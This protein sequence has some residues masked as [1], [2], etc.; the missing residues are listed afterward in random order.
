MEGWESEGGGTDRLED[1]AEGGEKDTTVHTIGTDGERSCSGSVGEQ[2]RGAPEHPGSPGELQE[3]RGQ[4]YTSRAPEHWT[5]LKQ[6]EGMRLRGSRQAAQELPGIP[7][8]TL[9]RG[10]VRC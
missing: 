4:A 8:S 10:Q 3:W 5:G 7:L 1:T 2:R 6:R 9:L